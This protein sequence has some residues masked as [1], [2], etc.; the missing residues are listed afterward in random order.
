MT[1]IYQ[2]RCKAISDALNALEKCAQ[3]LG[4]GCLAEIQRFEYELSMA[5]DAVDVARDRVS[6]LENALQ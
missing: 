3:A 5:E 6:E 4:R 1:T 2:S